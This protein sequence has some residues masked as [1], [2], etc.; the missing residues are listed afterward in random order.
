[1]K[2]DTPEGKKLIALLK[3]LHSEYEVET[4]P[5]RDPVLELVYS[6]LLWEATQEEADAALER[7]MEAVVDV[8]DLRVSLEGEV[9]E[10][11]GASY[12]LVNERVARLREAM[13]E[14][15]VREHSMEMRSV[16]SAA[17]KDQRV[18]LDSLPGMVP[19]VAGRVMLLSF[20]GHAMPVDR[21]LVVMLG[22][23]EVLEHDTPTDQAE[24]WLQRHI[25]ADE[26]TEAH[27]LFQ[28][29]ADDHDVPAEVFAPAVSVE[30]AAHEAPTSPLPKK[31]TATAG[32]RSKK[33]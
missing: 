29:W 11:V 23:E 31:G 10:M 18:Y 32:R 13:Y 12:P 30:Q 6:F 19:Y 3:R 17:K 9:V 33:K 27:M 1:M 8:N 20:G 4:P 2:N 16:A 21:K 14:V 25:K 28:A 15:Y 24:S 5:T 22:D 7:M 26:A